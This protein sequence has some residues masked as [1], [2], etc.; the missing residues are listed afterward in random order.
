MTWQDD[1]VVE[2]SSASSSSPGPEK[3]WEADQVVPSTSADQYAEPPSNLVKR[4]T[5]GLTLGVPMKTPDEAGK[6]LRDVWEATKTGWE[7]GSDPEGFARTW[8]QINN[9]TSAMSNVNPLKGLAEDASAIVKPLDAGMHLLSGVVGAVG[10]GL[11][12]LVGQQ[13]GAQPGAREGFKQTGAQ[14]LG[15]GIGMLG[16][17]PGPM[18]PLKSGNLARLVTDEVTDK[19]EAEP[20]GPMPTSQMVADTAAEIRKFQPITAYHGSPYSFDAFDIAKIGTGE[21]AQSYGHGL[22]FAEHP[23]VAE[24]YK[25]DSKM[26]SAR[27]GL[28]W[29]PEQEE[30]FQYLHENNYD[31]EAA[32]RDIEKRIGQ[33]KMYGDS[34]EAT[35]SLQATKA[36]I[37][38]GW[39][40][41]R[42]SLYQ[43]KIHANKDDFL[44]LDK[45][46]SEQQEILKKLKIVGLDDPML[47]GVVKRAMP[48][49][50]AKLREAGIPGIK[51]LDQGSRFNVKWK[52]VS[53]YNEASFDTK[54]AAEAHAE[55]LRQKGQTPT[56]TSPEEN[57][58]HNF[59]VFDHNDVE[60]T[61]RNG[62][63]VVEQK[64]ADYWQR[65]VH[66]AEVL[67]AAKESPPMARDLNSATTPPMPLPE[68]PPKT[69]LK[70]LDNRF[71]ALKGQAQAAKLQFQQFLEN[72]VPETFKN[73]EIQKKWYMHAEGDPQA[74]PMTAAEAK[75]YNDIFLPLRQREF[76]AFDELKQLRF[77]REEMAEMDP[78]YI[79]RAVVGKTPQIDRFAG[80]GE[81]TTP[82]YGP[83]IFNRNPSGAKARRYFAL[84]NEYGDRVLAAID[85]K[86]VT[87]IVKGVRTPIKHELETVAKGDTL[88]IDDQPWTVKNAYTREIEANTDTRYYQNALANIIDNTLHLES[89]V[90]ATYEIQRL[91]STD[92]WAAYTTSEHA[93]ETPKMPLFAN[94]KMDPKLAHVIDN[95]WRDLPTEG[96]QKALYAINRFAIGSLFW[97][98]IVHDLNMTSDW[99]TA[100]GWEN[101]TP[102]G[103]T[104]LFVDGAQA[105]KAVVNRDATYQRILSKG[106]GMQLGGVLT[107]KFY[108]NILQELGTEFVRNESKWKEVFLDSKFSPVAWGKQ[109]MSGANKSL[110]A[111]GDM[112][113]VQHVLGLMRKGLDEDTAITEANRF[114][115]TYR[116]LPDIA[117][118][119][120]VRDVVYNPLLF[121]FSRYHI[122]ILK[123][124]S[125]MAS[126]LVRGTG[127]GRID[128][129]GKV[130]SLAMLSMVLGPAL[131]A[132]VDK[133]T[134]TNI[135]IGPYGA[136][137][138]AYP[139]FEELVKATKDFWPQSVQSY[140]K[141]N[142]SFLGQILNLFQFAP[143]TQLGL[144]ILTNRD[145]AGRTIINLADMARGNFGHVAGQGA[146]FGAQTLLYPYNSAVQMAHSGLST[147]ENLAKLL[148]GARVHSVAQEKYLER[149]ERGEESAIKSRQRHPRGLIEGLTE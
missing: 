89:A 93:T 123:Q 54:D 56:I 76:A 45:L 81:E 58:T 71:Y 119:Q 18:V 26:I 101:V 125:N 1:T 31:Q 130:M 25:K 15:L 83:G 143:V 42:G 120:G 140:Y 132:L 105:L 33:A 117:G 57:L 73:T 88:T 10:Y 22:Y 103:M 4:L 59:V 124:Y 38:S 14:V 110:W 12:D 106:G 66:P 97:N 2:P 27:H 34:P 40:P 138:Y 85:G 74:E 9:A 3:A 92:E 62:V 98:P 36:V 6:S 65:G 94:D 70:D 139:A 51:Y 86:K 104:S 118:S 102:R 113:Y 30:A 146:E 46:L 49:I 20:V 136:A 78:E 121:E 35:A 144:G 126:D 134:G 8:A 108:E 96:I 60:I 29:T 133:T 61:H 114:L 44:D 64:V 23:E 80:E 17:K 149:Q 90:R 135:K 116:T 107:S 128:A 111:V 69:W 87:A 129:M 145:W 21:G 82:Y 148:F 55:T 24:A 95:H 147:T 50:V 48:D 16:A 99:L 43:V 115:A 32:S 13:F 100:R 77:P 63:P 137:R 142:K 67:E 127:Q 53:E 37:D 141:D 52:V 79:H 68:R 41:S 122:D 109:W 39:Q 91:R 84:E 28:D 5:Q 11:G 112:F 131:S 7:L 19:V 75:G 72:E 47:A